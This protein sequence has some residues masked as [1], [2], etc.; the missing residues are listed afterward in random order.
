M[1]QIEEG[2]ITPYSIDDV[3]SMASTSAITRKVRA[4]RRLR[5]A[6]S[7]S[8]DYRRLSHRYWRA[9]EGEPFDAE[10]ALYMEQ[11]TD[12]PLVKHNIFLGTINAVL[13]ADIAE[14][15]EPRFVGIDTSVKDQA[16]AE[17]F[18]AVV[19]RNHRRSGGHTRE[20]EM[21]LDKLITGSGWNRLIFNNKRF[22]FIL[23][24]ETVQ[25]WKVYPD[26]DASGV[27]RENMR[28]FF[29]EERWLWTD[30]KAQWPKKWADVLHTF[31]GSDVG[32]G[33]FG[34]ATGGVVRAVSN[35]YG[36]G[37]TSGGRSY[38]EEVEPTVRVLEYQYIEPEAYVAFTDPTTGQDS[39]LP[40]DEFFGD[41]RSMDPAKIGRYNELMAM[42]DPM[43]GQQ[44][45]PQIAYVEF[46]KDVYRRAYYI[47]GAGNSSEELIEMEDLPLPFQEFTYVNDTGFQSKDPEK[48]TTSTFG[49]GH[50]CFDPQKYIS[51]ILSF[52]LEMLRRSS[53]GGIY[54]KPSALESPGTFLQDYARPGA[55]ILIKEAA[56]IK[57]SIVERPGISW[58]SAME[59]FFGIVDDSLP[60]ITGVTR[61]FKGTSLQDRSA[62][63]INSLTSQTSS[64]L[65][66][67]VAPTMA[68]RKRLARLHALYVINYVSDDVINKVIG[69]AK[70]PGLTHEQDELTGG[71][72]YPPAMIPDPMG[73]PDPMTGMPMLVPN[74]DA[75]NPI[76]ILGADG[77][78]VTPAKLMRSAD[79]MEFD[80]EVDLGVASASTKE[81]VWRIFT[82]T[83]LLP[84]LAQAGVQIQDLL[85]ELIKYLPLPTEMAARLAKKF[86]MS[87]RN[88]GPDAILQQ[89]QQM[90]PEDLQQIYMAMG[91]MLGA[92]PEQGGVPQ[93]APPEMMQS[94]MGGE[95]P[96][97]PF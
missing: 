82:D 49:L 68:A 60:D 50:V 51:R 92:A 66:P 61:A 79:L 15:R 10:D 4:E 96:S 26:P 38:L 64:M 91:Q 17:W 8:S 65:N 5:A 90:P 13:G 72:K 24:Q 40:R 28:Y 75:N 48:G 78:P 44:L 55:P 14:V 34:G 2:G 45:F 80:V 70:I 56:N 63:A 73:Q 57:D 59:R 42:I 36:P 46:G 69:D 54:L 19:R 11:T 67:L 71:L 97:Q 6:M 85:P 18:T 47:A 95:V 16:I 20:Q 41:A 74:P 93:G 89:L 43:T 83:N 25:A 1:L 53:A 87:V 22:P 76:P 77:V 39:Q 88:S 30:V 23:Q 84:Q 7:G 9:Y 29:V 94:G 52:M 3:L 86:E 32:E 62:V 27:G 31:A 35:N 37:S 81:A 21:M 33:W 12:R 58:P